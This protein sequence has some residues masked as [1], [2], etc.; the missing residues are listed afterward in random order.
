[1]IP[2]RNLSMIASVLLLTFFLVAPVAA[3]NKV[4]VIPLMKDAPPLEP[5]A[6]VTA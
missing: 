6:P 4:V 5:W 1:M 3:H 2:K